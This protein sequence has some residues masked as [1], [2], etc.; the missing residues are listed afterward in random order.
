MTEKKAKGNIRGWIILITSVVLVFA[1]LPY[2]WWK[3]NVDYDNI[4]SRGKS[5]IGK[6]I[7]VTG[8]KENHTRI[9]YFI[10]NQKIVVVR[11]APSKSKKNIG[12]NVRLLYDSLDYKNVIILW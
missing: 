3:G 7:D 6:V 9:E 10:D 5:T 1:V 4:K 8:F 11:D 2:A 12:D